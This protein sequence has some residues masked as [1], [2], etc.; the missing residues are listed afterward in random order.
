MCAFLLTSFIRMANG[1]IFVDRAL[2]IC[3]GAMV[4]G[5]QCRLNFSDWFQAELC[6]ILMRAD[7]G[8][9]SPV[10]M[11]AMQARAVQVV[12]AYSTSLKADE[13]A[14]AFQA[15]ARLMAA[16]DLV[17]GFCSARCISHLALLHVKGTEESPQLLAV[18]EHSVLAL[19][20]AF[21]LANRSESE[22]C[23]R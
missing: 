1:G 11:R 21:G 10:E 4:G 5:G 19:G 15:I 8:E 17:T 14:I 9:S 23:L 6:P 3:R 22:E 12:Q 13:F 20:N 7:L 18:R 2:E 16:S